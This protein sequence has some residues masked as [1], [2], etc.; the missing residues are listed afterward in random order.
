[1]ILPRTRFECIT[2]Y[3]KD[4]WSCYYIPI[5]KNANTSVTKWFN[6]H[7]VFTKHGQQYTGEVLEGVKFLVLR[8]PLKRIISMFFHMLQEV[9]KGKASFK[10]YGF[11]FKKNHIEY[12]EFKI[13][14]VDR[15]NLFLD[16][17]KKNKFYDLHIFPQIFFLKE[18]GLSPEDVDILLFDDLERD[19]DNFCK[20]YGFIPTQELETLNITKNKFGL[21]SQQEEIQKYID[22]HIDVQNKMKILYQEDWDLYNK[23]KDSRS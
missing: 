6:G 23:I 17:I 8:N 9:N 22:S 11:Y 3:Y 12:P 18:T 7:S 2:L 5:P 19:I 4:K 10:E 15:F 21:G 16:S 20:K 13:S 14:L 1:M